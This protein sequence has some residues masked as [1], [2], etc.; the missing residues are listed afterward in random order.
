MVRVKEFFNDRENVL[1]VNG[2]ITFFLHRCLSFNDMEMG[3]KDCS[4][5]EKVTT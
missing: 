2:D 3:F 5:G 1:G 4:T